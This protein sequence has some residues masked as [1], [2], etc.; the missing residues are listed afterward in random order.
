MSDFVPRIA[1]VSL[2]RNDA[3]RFIARRMNNLAGKLGVTRWI[4]VVGDS[5][6][7]TEQVL[8]DFSKDKPIKVIRHDTG[9]VGDTPEFRLLRLSHTVNAALDDLG[10]LDDYM[11]LHESDIQSPEDVAVKLNAV[12]LNTGGQVAAG[13][14]VL[15][16]AEPGPEHELFYDTW[17]YRKNGQCFANGWPYHPAF[18][19]AEAFEVDSVGTVWIAPAVDFREGVRCRV[20]GAVELCRELKARGRR[21][22]VDPT[23]R[24]VQPRELWKAQAHPQEAVARGLG[25]A[26]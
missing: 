19:H 14:P 3:E 25:L 11:L 17:A 18:N 26:V 9:I 24:I 21:I 23:L 5:T 13:W 6:D 12:L 2:W 15:P 8:R 16:G 10:P 1:M 22:F 4:W 20:F 7:P